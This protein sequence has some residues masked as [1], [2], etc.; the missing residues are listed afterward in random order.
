M[1]SFATYLAEQRAADPDF[2]ADMAEMR[3][4]VE[5][6]VAQ[7]ECKER[8]TGEAMQALEHIMQGDLE[9]ARKVLESI[10]ETEASAALREIQE[11]AAT[12]SD[13]ARDLAG[14][15][16]QRRAAARATR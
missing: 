11:G 15:R 5:A 16:E 13:L 2:D 6:E 3:T 10:P 9:Q 12:L 4:V 1:K 7:A 8:A 14:N